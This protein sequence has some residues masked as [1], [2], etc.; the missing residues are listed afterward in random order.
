MNCVGIMSVTLATLTIG[1][2]GG[3]GLRAAESAPIAIS[4]LPIDASSMRSWYSGY[5][6]IGVAL[7]EE[8]ADSLRLDRRY[9]VG[10]NPSEARLVIEGSV[11]RFSL[12]PKPSGVVAIVPPP[13][14]S[15]LSR[16][17]PAPRRSTA[18]EMTIAIRVRDART[19][20]LLATADG[21]GTSAGPM[22]VPL[23]AVSAGEDASASTWDWGSNNPLTE[24]KDQAFSSMLASLRQSMNRVLQR[25]AR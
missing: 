17:F 5:S 10:P 6:K 19:S 18:V 14:R 8:I 16:W 22:A 2:S 9:R 25:S 23:R 12:A 4:V 7:A 3:I 21:S 1:G 24:A 11:A 15:A 13:L 20:R